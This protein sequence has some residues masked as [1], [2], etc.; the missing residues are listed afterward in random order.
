MP[1]NTTTICKTLD[2]IDRRE[3]TPV[4]HDKPVEWARCILPSMKDFILF[5]EEKEGTS[6]MMRRAD[7][8]ANISIVHHDNGRGWEPL[9]PYQLGED[10]KQHDIDELLSLIYSKPRNG[11]VLRKAYRKKVPNRQLVDLPSENAVGL[12]MRWKPPRRVHFDKPWL[13]LPVNR[14][15]KT[16]RH[17]AYRDSMVATLHEH[18]VVPMLAVRQNI[19]RWALSKYHG[20][21][22]GNKGHL[23]FK[24]AYGELSREDIPTIHVDLKQFGHVL[25]QC[26]RLHDQKREFVAWMASQGL[27]VWPLKYETFLQEPNRFFRQMLTRLGHKGRE[28]DIRRVLNED[29]KLQ[30]VHSGHISE[31]VENHE[32]LTSTYG[33]CFESWDDIQTLP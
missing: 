24:L 26:R 13:D 10:V 17:R 7:R 33:S 1:L 18:G 15:L 9:E 27:E 19:F 21:G 4:G 11:E 8:F 20:D 23:Q 29:I 5:F 2:T 28:E 32:E 22:Q 31:Y 30:R 16:R 25:D 14:I 12:K 6:A 3:G